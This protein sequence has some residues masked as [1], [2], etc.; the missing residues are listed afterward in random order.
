MPSETDWLRWSLYWKFL[1]FHRASRNHEIL[2]INYL[3]NID[4]VNGGF[5][6]FFVSHFSFSLAV[7]FDLSFGLG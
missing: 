2:S 1:V 3:V 4:G 5:V 6:S 7:D